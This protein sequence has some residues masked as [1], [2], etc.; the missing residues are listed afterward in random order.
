MEQR[1]K[2]ERK[3]QN[4]EETAFF[5]I[6]KTTIENTSERIVRTEEVNPDVTPLPKE[7]ESEPESK[8]GHHYWGYF[9]F[10][11]FVYFVISTLFDLFG[12]D[13]SSRLLLDNVIPALGFAVIFTILIGL[14][15]HKRK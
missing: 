4:T 11:F 9:L 1:A 5:T 13:F 2:Q 6:D 15:R 8:S 7:Q 14:L 10:V 3:T 12:E